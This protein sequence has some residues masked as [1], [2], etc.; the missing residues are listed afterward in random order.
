LLGGDVGRET[1]RRLMAAGVVGLPLRARLPMPGLAAAVRGGL[2]V[3]SGL[4][5]GARLVAVEA[6]LPVA[7]RTALAVALR[8][9][10][11]RLPLPLRLRLPLSLPL[12]LSLGAL[13]AL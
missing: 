12:S 7:I 11:L 6:R 10:A 2:S 1:R 3:G 8:A 13:L 9:R 5:A 4:S